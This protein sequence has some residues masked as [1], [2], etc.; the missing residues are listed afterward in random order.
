MHI[1]VYIKSKEIDMV[2]DNIYETIIIKEVSWK[3]SVL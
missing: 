3:S 2:F 1:N